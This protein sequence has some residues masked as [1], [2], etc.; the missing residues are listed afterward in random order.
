MCA[1]GSRPS[2]T[3][4]RAVV[5]FLVVVLIPVLL[6]FAVLTI[7]VGV[8]F[9]T[10][11][12]LQNAA[13]AG[14]L[15]ATVILADD[16]SDAG[17]AKARAAAIEVIQRHATLGGRPLNIDPADLV[18]GKVELDQIANQ[19]KF[20]PTEVLPNGVHIDIIKSA[21]SANGAIPLFF[22]SIFGRKTSD[23]TASATAALAGTRDIA[24]VFDLTYTMNSDSQL[25]HARPHTAEN[26]TAL[27]GMQI[28]LRDIWCALDGPA[29]SRPYLP[30]E[31]DETEY[32]SDTG[33]TIGAM[34]TWGLPIVPNTYDP[35][36][37]PGLWYIPNSGAC[38]EAGVTASLTARGYNAAR[39]ANIMAGPSST[40]SNRT[41]VMIGLANWTPSSA[42][43]TSV[44][45]GELTW[46]A[47]PSYATGWTWSNYVSFVAS[48]SSNMYS[49][50]S[51]LRYRFGV[52]TYTN[53]LL[54]RPR[55]NQTNILWQTPEL[56]I[57]AIK[58][59]VQTFVDVLVD[60]GNRDHVSLETF[61]NIGR[62]QIDLTDDLQSIP[63][64]LYELQAAHWEQTTNLGAGIA[65]GIE[66]LTSSRARPESDKVIIVLSDG[67]P[68]TNEEG[69]W[70]G[71]GSLVASNHALAQA[72][73]AADENIRIYAITVGLDA[74]RDLMQQ[75]AKIGNGRE[76]YAAGD[77]AEYTAQLQEI[78]FRLAGSDIAMLVE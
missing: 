34:S 65:E 35:T 20:T 50:D 45:S 14:A 41:A 31:E 17:V 13:D 63:D 18:F 43:D 57:Q 70:D 22:A 26:G 46:I 49:G 74:N 40:W 12:D 52:K 77:P 2:S 67:Q 7:D 44:S 10:R 66:E 73:R 51:R 9:N 29:P 25:Y 24:V 78:F 28:N 76:F 55:Y 61:D 5:V 19:Y 30:G 72:Q 39:R 48:T 27:D 75:I 38:T 56:P 33:P 16:R 42:G 8:L 3:H 37:D 4:R 47:L 54:E 15:A 59:A 53:F 11:A 68:N 60:S 64:R 62:H 32:A 69:A 71:Y 1:Y 58:D 23:V 36:T 6:G 21:G